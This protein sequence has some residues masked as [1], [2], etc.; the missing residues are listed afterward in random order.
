MYATMAY[1]AM[2]RLA[3][4]RRMNAAFR[5]VAGLVRARRAYAAA[6]GDYCGILIGQLA[7]SSLAECLPILPRYAMDC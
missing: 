5:I 6:G 1:A 7:I 3:M 4:V 2:L